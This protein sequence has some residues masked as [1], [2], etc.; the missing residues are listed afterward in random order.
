MDSTTRENKAELI[1]ITSSDGTL[2]DSLRTYLLNP[3]SA[4]LAGFS[5]F[6]SI[7]LVTKF[8]GYLIGSYEIFTIGISDVVYS[9]VG[10][11]LVTS[12]KF[13]TFF[14]KEDN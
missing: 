13:L 2:K 3:L 8:V 11:L 14:I 9:L 6:F 4:G 12:E 7:I 5:I 10:F 1:Q